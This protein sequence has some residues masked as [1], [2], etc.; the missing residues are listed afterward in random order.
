MEAQNDEQHL[1]H[2]GG[3][4]NNVKSHLEGSKMH[5]KKDKKQASKRKGSGLS[6]SQ[7]VQYIKEKHDLQTAENEAAQ[8][9]LDAEEKAK[10]AE[11]EKKKYFGVPKTRK[12]K[13]ALADLEYGQ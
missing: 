7:R 3:D 12:V 1:N 6:D 10:W 11:E 4:K 5:Y 9:R 8:A 2:L 13:Q